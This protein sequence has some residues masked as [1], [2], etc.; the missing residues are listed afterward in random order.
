MT[1]H[2]VVDA[3]RRALGERRVGHA[4]T[5]DPD[6]TGVLLVGV[7]SATRLLRFGTELPKTYTCEIVFGVETDTL[8]DSGAVVARHAMAPVDLDRA[9]QVVAEH[10][11]GP[12]MQVPP[13]VS[14]LHVGGRRLH[15]LARKGIEVE[16]A[17][18]PVEVYRFELDHGAPA[19]V[20]RAVVD[21]STGTYVRALA[22]DL[23]RL[24]GG[25]AHL[26][27]LRRTAI[28]PHTVATATP[29]DALHLLPSVEVVRHFDRVEV[30]EPTAARVAHGGLLADLPGTGPWAVVA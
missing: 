25:G 29:I 8:D 13:M 24:L 18:R 1:S 4:G 6:A 5:L 9:R 20:L 19:D 17:P 14:A 21:C 28:G 16:R 22:A 23:G 10:L 3:V 15:E 30:D 2:D 12:I 27:A 11:V 26:R 7:G